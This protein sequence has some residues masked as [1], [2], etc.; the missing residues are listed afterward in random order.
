MKVRNSTSTAAVYGELGRYPLY[1][2]R[3]VRILKYWFKIRNTDNIVLQTMS[4]VAYNDCNNGKKNWESN[5]K[6]MLNEYGFSHVWDFPSSVNFNVF[7]KIFKQRVIDCFLQSWCTSKENSSVLHLYNFIKESF[8]YEQYLDILPAY[9]YPSVCRLRLSAHSLIIET[10]RYSC[11]RTVRNERLCELCDNKD[12]ED[13]YH[14]ILICP[15]Y[16]FLRKKYIK[17]YYYKRPSVFK[18]IQLFMSTSKTELFNLAN[19]IKYAL[20]SRSSCM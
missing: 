6:R 13:E 7:I 9:L 3:F 14:F 4:N 12:I 18:L 19:F 20:C 17:S 1:I 11:N 2:S 15:R 5:V 16:L 8:G 10:G